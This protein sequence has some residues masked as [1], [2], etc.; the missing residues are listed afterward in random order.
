MPKSLTSA[1]LAIVLGLL[2]AASSSSS[3]A[4]PEVDALI[5]QLSD[6]DESVRLKAAKELGKLKEK[7]KDAIPALKVA[8]T[9]SDE[10]VREVAKKALTAI[11]EATD[12]IDAAKV[13]EKLV[14]L[15]KDMRSKDN[16]V[17]LAAIAKL[18]ELGADAKPAGAAIVEYGMMSPNAAVKN[19]AN[20]AF[21]KI[22]PLVHKEIITVYYDEDEKKKN[23]A[24]TSLQLMGSKAKA[25]VPIIKGYHQFLVGKH[26]YTPSNTLAALVKIAPDDESVQ[27]A[28]LALVGG[29]DSAL[30]WSYIRGSDREFVVN[31][32]HELK[33]DDKQKLAPLV[34][35]LAAAGTRS[36]RRDRE[37]MI[38]ELGKLRV[39][40]KEKYPALMTALSKNTTER[41]LIINE[42]AKLG[43]DAKGALPVLMALKTDKEEAVRIAANNAIEAIK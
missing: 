30:P 21:E 2:V 28:I 10:D 43:T 13:D 19:A 27:A 34:S 12:K 41:A 37:M 23:A 33:I 11:K 31:L 22:D 40:N 17:R 15:I 36:D 4:P 6:K 14:P 24:V 32:M 16:K 7:A 29:S 42:L 8:T 18:E 35:G 39:E 20:A 26:R 5:K 25:A 3:A 1:V 38:A 9:D